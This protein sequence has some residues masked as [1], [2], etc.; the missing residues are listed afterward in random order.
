MSNTHPASR[1]V[2]VRRHPSGRATVELVMYKHQVFACRRCELVRNRR[3]NATDVGE[4][5]LC[6]CRNPIKQEQLTDFLFGPDDHTPDYPT[7][8]DE[9]DVLD[10]D[11][12]RAFYDL[13]DS[14]QANRELRRVAGF[15]AGNCFFCHN[16]G[17]SEHYY[18][19]TDEEWELEK[20]RPDKAW[21]IHGGGRLWAVT[22][23]TD[24][25]GPD[26]E[27]GPWQGPSPRCRSPHWVDLE[28]THITRP[29][30][31]PHRGIRR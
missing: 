10:I 7:L 19:W 31:G 9:V 17:R 20:H 8:H 21:P 12:D 28:S 16:N 13:C 11:E 1:S 14:L 25:K 23:R 18:A 29:T 3:C 27:F 26:C 24:I 22:V 6:H 30:Y 15:T 5:G 4:T 2:K